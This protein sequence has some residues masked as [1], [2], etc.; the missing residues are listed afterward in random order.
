MT[1]DLPTAPDATG[2]EVEPVAGA[3]PLPTV[4]ARYHHTT[5]S[6]EQGA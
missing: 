3:Y 2:L 5:T 6:E 1:R 4:A